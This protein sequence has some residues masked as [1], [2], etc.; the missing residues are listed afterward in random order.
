M[1]NHGCQ[2]GTRCLFSMP[3]R[4]KC[5]LLVSL[6]TCSVAECAGQCQLQCALLKHN[7]SAT[8]RQST[9]FPEQVCARLESLVTV[10][11]DYGVMV[12]RRPGQKVTM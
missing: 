5:I 8:L 12:T 4:T 1:G 10:S 7:S 11:G 9:L 3:N 2:T 6:M